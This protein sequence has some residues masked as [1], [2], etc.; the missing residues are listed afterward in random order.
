VVFPA[1]GVDLWHE[2]GPDEQF[3][4]LVE[5]TVRSRELFREGLQVG[6][7]PSWG[8]SSGPTDWMVSNWKPCKANTPRVGVRFQ[9]SMDTLS[10]LAIRGVS[11]FWHQGQAP[12]AVAVEQIRKEKVWPVGPKVHGPR[13]QARPCQGGVIAQ[14]GPDD[15]S[16]R[17]LNKVPGQ[18]GAPLQEV[19][20]V[21]RKQHVRHCCH[22]PANAALPSPAQGVI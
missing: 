4:P 8:P 2:Y 14:Q 13:Q 12:K 15:E 22:L 5:V 1:V 20:S 19:L 21:V 10:I 3:R 17:R 7:R 6:T 16:L 9:S 11:G 18:V